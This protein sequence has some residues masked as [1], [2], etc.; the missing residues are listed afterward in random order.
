[1]AT[2]SAIWIGINPALAR[3]GAPLRFPRPAY[4]RLNPAGLVA[5]TITIPARFTHRCPVLSSREFQAGWFEDVRVAYI[6]KVQW[7]LD[8]AGRVIAGCPATYEF[9]INEPGGAVRRVSRS[10]DPLFATDDER[11]AFKAGQTFAMNESG[12]F[13]RWSWSGPDLPGERPAYQ[14]LVPAAD[15]RIWV[16]PSQPMIPR[17]LPTP[18]PRGLPAVI[19]EESRT[20]VFDVFG[21]DGQWIGAVRLPPSLPYVPWPETPDPVIRGDTLWGV[22]V[23]SLEV[24]Y[25]ARFE[26]VWRR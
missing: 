16:W 7:A 26:V 4:V 21:P 1:V 5:D 13:E 10:W 14:R 8:R 20:G 15:G 18:R 23:D 6:P 12:Y 3:D 22:T 25:V 9:D 17:E 24:E 19:Y 2:D 11:A